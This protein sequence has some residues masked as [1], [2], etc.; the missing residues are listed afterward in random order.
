MGYRAGPVTLSMYIGKPQ[1][2]V[3]PFQKY[4]AINTRALAPDQATQRLGRARA[5]NPQGLGS[6]IILHDRKLIPAR[7][8]PFAEMHVGRKRKVRILNAVNKVAVNTPGSCERNSR[9][10][11]TD[12]WQK[13]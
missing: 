10:R 3:E 9:L 1:T 5:L 7:N 11:A 4:P 8:N 12:S 2:N 13:L 6:A